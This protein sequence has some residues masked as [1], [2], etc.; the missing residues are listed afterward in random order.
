MSSTFHN[1]TKEAIVVEDE[2]SPNDAMAEF[3]GVEGRKRL[4]RKL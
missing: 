3:G 2:P 4:E 1:D